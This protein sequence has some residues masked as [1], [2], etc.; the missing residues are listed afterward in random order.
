MSRSDTDRPGV[1]EADVVLFRMAR[2]GFWRGSEEGEAGAKKLRGT[3][4][5]GGVA[6]PS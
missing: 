1:R 3:M 2:K 5:S 4:F 6:R